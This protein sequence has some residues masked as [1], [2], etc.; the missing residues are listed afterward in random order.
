M[1]LETRITAVIQR[2][3]DQFNSL[4]DFTPGLLDGEYH[5]DVEDGVL[6]ETIAFGDLC[7][8]KA[9]DLLTMGLRF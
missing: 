4:F 7:Y 8:F 1:S 5:G 2:I 3:R 6:G 9:A